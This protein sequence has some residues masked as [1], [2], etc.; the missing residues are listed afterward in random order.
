MNIII[1][2]ITTKAKDIIIGESTQNH[3]QSITPTSLN[4]INTVARTPIKPIPPEELLKF[5]FAIVIS[6]K[7][8]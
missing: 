7:S 6:L 3:V 4:T 2:T 5:E 8:I 1:A